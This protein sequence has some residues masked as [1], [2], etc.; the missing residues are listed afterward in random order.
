MGPQGPRT[1]AVAL[2]RSQAGRGLGHGVGDVGGQRLGR[3]ADAEGDD[4]G[5]W[6]LLLVGRA[7]ARDLEGKRGAVGA[8]GDLRLSM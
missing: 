8:E 1:P 7:A 6:V 5:I 4:L 2:A 3:V